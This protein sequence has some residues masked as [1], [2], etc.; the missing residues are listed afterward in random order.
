MNLIE[1][2]IDF[3]LQPEIYGTAITIILSLIVY[4]LAI[5]ITNK[6]AFNGKTPYQIK[7]SKTVI[8]LVQNVIKYA[9]MIIALIIILELF[10]IDTISIIAGLGVVGVVLGLALQDT[11]KDIISGIT[12]I[13]EN[14]FVVGDIVR[15]PNTNNFTGEVIS[16]GLKSTRIKSVNGEVLIIANRNIIE[17]I[18][19]SQK[20]ADV[21]IDIPI[22]YEEKVEKVEKVINELISEMP[23]IEGIKENKIEYLG[24]QDLDVN[25]VN[26]RIKITCHQEQQWGIRRE[27][28]K[29]IKMKLDKS[30]IKIPYPQ[31]EVHSGKT[32]K[33]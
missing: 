32:N 21:I 8:N 10:G 15:Y 30:N 6:I 9:I 26:Y 14:Y 31:L 7:R 27:C 23:T 18:N 16:F 3:I 19:I 17:I 11:L 5:Q 1:N 2:I 29:L 22:A 33:N 20:S 4:R 25:S 13:L 12:I 24:I 28:L